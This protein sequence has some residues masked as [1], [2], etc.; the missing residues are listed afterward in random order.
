MARRVE[1]GEPVQILL[2][3]DNTFELDED[4]L[5]RILLAERVKDKPVVVVSVAGASRMGKSFLLNFFVRYMRSSDK[6]NWLGDPS[7]PLTGFSWS[8]GSDGNTRGIWI[9][10]EVFLVT[11]PQGEQVAV[12][13]MDTQGSFDRE[14][15]VQECTTIFA[16]S[17]LCSSVQVYNLFHNILRN[18]LQNLEYFTHYGRLAQ[19]GQQCLTGTPFQKLLFLVRDWRCPDEA[20]YGAEGGRKF[21]EKC[22]KVSE[23]DP[24]ELRDMKRRIK[25]CFKE[26]GCFLMP[27]P[28]EKVDTAGKFDGRLSDIKET[29]KLQLQQLLPS[30]LAADKLLVKE[31][32]GQKI[33]CELLMD[34][35]KAYVEIFKSGKLPQIESTL[36]VTAKV[37]NFH[38]M[39]AAM[40]RYKDAMKKVCNEAQGYLPFLTLAGYH[41]QNK[42]LAITLFVQTKKMGGKEFSE[43]FLHRLEEDIEQAFSDF[44]RRNEEKNRP[45]TDAVLT[46]ISIGAGVAAA[47]FAAAGQFGLAM[48]CANVAAT[49]GP[50]A[51]HIREKAP[52]VLGNILVDDTVNIACNAVTGRGFP[53]AFVQPDD[54]DEEANTASGPMGMKKPIPR[55]PIRQFKND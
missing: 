30:L 49:V 38:A 37:N 53:D 10:D 51:Q 47:G 17:T 16:L 28:G 42:R 25:S 13:L 55:K 4:P 11:S 6:N 34:Y 45:Q 40:G 15:T 50:L 18:D 27:H 35:I 7:V 12:I 54:W 20:P 32:N 43:G 14:S 41:M 19:E 9:W 52:G 22:L 21:I 36:K 31:V 24:E 1:R 8:G 29:F 33:T 44:V 39:D 46:G 23:K 26:C 5:K 3:K 2:E 48:G